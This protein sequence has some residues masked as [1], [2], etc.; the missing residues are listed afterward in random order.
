MLTPDPHKLSIPVDPD[1]KKITKIQVKK[2]L[3]TPF[4]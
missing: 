4:T 2:F 3:I 1:D